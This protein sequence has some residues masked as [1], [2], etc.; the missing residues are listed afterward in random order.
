MSS[1]NSNSGDRSFP[2][3]AEDLA[4]ARELRAVR[5]ERQRFY[6]K[7]DGSLKALFSH[8]EWRIT[9]HPNGLIELIVT[10]PSLVIYKR[11]YNRAI[12][13]QRRLEE[14]VPLQHTRFQLEY[15]P[16]PHTYYEHEVLWGDETDNFF[17]DDNEF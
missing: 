4:I 1:D 10:C 2:L 6:N 7:L 15:P 9:P 5:I 17:N 12:G 13:I 8:C 14:I 11:L 16:L 3:S